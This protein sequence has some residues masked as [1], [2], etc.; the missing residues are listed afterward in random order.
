MIRAAERRTLFNRRKENFVG[1]TRGRIPL[2][3]ILSFDCVVLDLHRSLCPS[4]YRGSVRLL[5]AAAWKAATGRDWNGRRLLAI[6][7]RVRDLPEFVGNPTTVLY[8]SR[9][10]QEVARE[11]GAPISEEEAHRVHDEFVSPEHYHFPRAN[12][13]LLAALIRIWGDAVYIA[14]SSEFGLAVRLIERHRIDRMVPLG[15]VFTPDRLDGARKPEVLFFKRV[16]ERIGVKPE[17]VLALLDSPWNDL[18]AVKAGMYGLF[19]IN[20]R[21]LHRVLH[22]HATSFLSAKD[23]KRIN[24]VCSAEAAKEWVDKHARNDAEER[25]EEVEPEPGRARVRRVA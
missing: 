10:N 24:A 11:Y 22:A 4:K 1:T 13:R 15:Q 9:V 6:T 23:M 18:A 16:A 20:E 3:G 7:R 5:Y 8:W 25:D 17:R 21:R 14:T 19:L 12:E 2:P